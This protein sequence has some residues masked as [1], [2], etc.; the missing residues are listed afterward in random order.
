[1][2]DNILKRLSRAEADIRALTDAVAQ[3]RDAIRIPA[4]RAPPTLAEIRHM[5]EAVV[6]A[7]HM[8]GIPA[9]MIY[10][11]SRRASIAEARQR[12]YTIAHGAGMA[13]AAIARAMGIDH[14]TVLH[15]IR[16]SQQRALD[17]T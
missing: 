6:Q 2:T 15:G 7:A 17:G 9:E 12:A 13:S 5:H 16:R 11:T 10:G 1:M 8:T 14:T 3:M 4:D